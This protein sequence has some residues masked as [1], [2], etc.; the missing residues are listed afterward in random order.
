MDRFVVRRVVVRCAISSLDK[1]WLRIAVRSLD[2]AL[3]HPE[4]R[5]HIAAC[6]VSGVHGGA[7]DV[8]D[9]HLLRLELSSPSN[10]ESTEED[11]VHTVRY[12]E[13]EN[14]LE[15]SHKA[16]R[17]ASKAQGEAELARAGTAE[18]RAA[19]LVANEE[20][21]ALLRA[22]LAREASF[23]LEDA[24]SIDDGSLLVSLFDVEAG[25]MEVDPEWG[26]ESYHRL[27]GLTKPGLDGSQWTPWQSFSADVEHALRRAM[28]RAIG[29]EAASGADFRVEGA[30]VEVILKGAGTDPAA[31]TAS[32]LRGTLDRQLAE[33]QSE[34]WLGVLG[35]W[36]DKAR[37]P[38]EGREGPEPEAP[39]ASGDALDS[40]GETHY[41]RPPWRIRGLDQRYSNG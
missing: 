27:R 18:E 4:T 14:R 39:P 36:L 25:L 16:T 12:S 15:A 10:L 1:D 8:P 2:E 5:P 33:R 31:P 37:H 6:T 24:S 26:R 40:A 7:G 23:V 32:Q 30:T 3:Q 35:G 34:L 28:R 17:E 41:S 9:W 38:A 22:R 29:K 11:R 19:V 21:A 13:A 20:K